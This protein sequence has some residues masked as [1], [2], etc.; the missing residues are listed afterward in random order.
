MLQLDPPTF[1]PSQAEGLKTLLGELDSD[2]E[3]LPSTSSN[4][5]NAQVAAALNPLFECVHLPPFSS[6]SLPF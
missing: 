3:E 6:S 2:A 1:S 4:D 5:P